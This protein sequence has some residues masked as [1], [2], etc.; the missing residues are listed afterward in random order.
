MYWKSGEIAEENL[1]KTKNRDFS[2]LNSRA[3][4]QNKTSR[5]SCRRLFENFLPSTPT[6]VTFEISQEVKCDC[7]DCF[8]FS[9][10]N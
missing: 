5:T 1:K 10:K 7:A 4:S 9:W 6:E 2:I 8:I 3:P